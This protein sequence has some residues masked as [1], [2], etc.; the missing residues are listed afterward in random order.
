ML[1]AF[2]FRHVRGLDRLLGESLERAWKAGAGPAGGRLGI[3][4]DSF[5]GQVCGR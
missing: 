1:R 2:T 3:D 5:V 4:V